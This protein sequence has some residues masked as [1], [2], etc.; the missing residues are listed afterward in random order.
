MVQP[1]TSTV[2]N[3]APTDVTQLVTCWP[4]AAARVVQISARPV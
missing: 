4:Y 3:V 2:A 1:S